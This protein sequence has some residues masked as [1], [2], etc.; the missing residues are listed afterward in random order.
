MVPLELLGGAG[1]G[2][3]SETTSI[4]LVGRQHLDGSIVDRCMVAS[5][6]ECFELAKQLGLPFVGAGRLQQRDRRLAV[7]ARGLLHIT[8]LLPQLG[9]AGDVD[10]VRASTLLFR[11]VR[12]CEVGTGLAG[13]ELGARDLFDL[14]KEGSMVIGVHVQTGRGQVANMV[15]ARSP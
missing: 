9:R 15:T 4:V 10:H 3:A 1:A 12:R 6:Q 14:R 13:E 11:P 2:L 5:V 8:H 7:T